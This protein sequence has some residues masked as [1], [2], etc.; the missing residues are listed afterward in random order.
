M[1]VRPRDPII[2]SRAASLLVRPAYALSLV[3]FVVLVVGT[4]VSSERRAERNRT[5]AVRIGTPGRGLGYGGGLGY[6]AGHANT[7]VFHPRAGLHRDRWSRTG[8]VRMAW[9]AI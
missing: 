1:R 2:C 7:T 3:I 6:A 5:H 4:A 9:T 8:S